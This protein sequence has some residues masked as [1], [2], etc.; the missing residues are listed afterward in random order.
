MKNIKLILALILFSQLS[1]A[2]ERIVHGIVKDSTG[3]A[4]LGANILIKRTHMSTQTDIDGKFE[5][6]A[7]I[8][9]T[10]IFSFVGMKEK[11]VIAYQNEMNVSFREYKFEPDCDEETLL[12]SR[13]KYR[14]PSVFPPRAYKKNI[15]KSDFRRSI[16]ANYIVIYLINASVLCKIDHAFEKKFG[17]HYCRT[18]FS[19]DE[20]DAIV[21]N[22]NEEYTKTYNKLVFKRLNKKF[23]KAWQSEIRKEAVGLEDFIKK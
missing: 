1:F 21:Y 18:Y 4:L 9:D 13:K 5:I 15:P 2:Q 11:K 17:I 14:H 12:I 6:K 3:L 7:K 8:N 23:K 19:N 22:H 10:L 20:E 16:K